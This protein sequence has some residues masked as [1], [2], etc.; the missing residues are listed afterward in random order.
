VRLLASLRPREQP[1]RVVG[2]STGSVPPPP[3]SLSLMSL[4]LLT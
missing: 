3:P 2:Q 1:L 4:V